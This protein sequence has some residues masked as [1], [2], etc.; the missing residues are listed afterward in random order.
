MADE[1]YT[2]KLFDW[3]NGEKFNRIDVSASD[4]ARCMTHENFVYMFDSFLNY[5]GKQY[6]EGKNV[7]KDLRTTH[8][9]LQRSAIAFALGLIVGISDQEYTD[10]RNETAIETAKKI[11]E[12]YKNGEIPLGPYL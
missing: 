5:G 3:N 8:R 6:H 12:L 9:T 7:G 2:V 11:A 1:K 10:A 4:I